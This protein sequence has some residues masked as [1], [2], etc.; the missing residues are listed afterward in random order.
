MVVVAKENHLGEKKQM[1]YSDLSTMQFALPG[2]R[3][4]SAIRRK[5]DQ[6]L[7]EEKIEPKILAE[8][9]DIHALL[10]IAERGN[11]ATILSR[12][13]VG[14]HSGLKIMSLP[15][16]PLCVT[17]GIMWHKASSIKSGSKSLPGCD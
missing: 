16:K 17:S 3:G 10:T 9:N 13:A 5:V 6:R 4:A 14:N 8:M 12:T 11:A 7:A 15:G 2:R 1:E